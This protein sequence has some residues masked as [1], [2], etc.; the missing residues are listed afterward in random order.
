MKNSY[1]RSRIDISNK[2]KR[3]E[4]LRLKLNNCDLFVYVCSTRPY[5]SQLS[6]F[7]VRRLTFF[8][9]IKSA[10]WQI[11]I[12]KNYS[13]DDLFAPLVFPRQTN[14]SEKRKAH[15]LFST[16][17]LFCGPKY[18]SGGRGGGKEINLS[19]H[20]N[21]CKQSPGNKEMPILLNELPDWIFHS[22]KTPKRVYRRF[23]RSV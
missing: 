16:K 8:N 18:V 4:Y 15:F 22:F 10:S 12:V 5:L 6:W 11:F 20:R 17:K 23:W 14:L 1:S 3:L 19:W 7:E 13:Y 9:H 21:F 2:L